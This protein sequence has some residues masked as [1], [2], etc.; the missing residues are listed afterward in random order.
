MEGHVC[1]NI[2][3]ENWSAALNLSSITYGLMFLF[4]APNADDPLNKEAA[5]FMRTRPEEFERTVRATMRG[6]FFYGT[7]F[8]RLI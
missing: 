1:L 4:V 7:H 2:L 5:E 6:G 3:R 8:P